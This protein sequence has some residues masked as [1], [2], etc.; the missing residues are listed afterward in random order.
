MRTSRVDRKTVRIEARN[1]AESIVLEVLRAGVA[2]SQANRN[3]PPGISSAYARV[4]ASGPSRSS[5]SSKASSFGDKTW[6]VRGATAAAKG[7][8][9]KL[10]D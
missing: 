9:I 2:R 3:D 10:P 8:R 7:H 4:M 5:S 6:H 1:H